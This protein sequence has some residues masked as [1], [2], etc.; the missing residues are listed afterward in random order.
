MRCRPALAALATAVLA[1]ACGGGG[2][3]APPTTSA[4][5]FPLGDL[6]VQRGGATVLSL[7]VEVADNQA[8]WEK[9]LMGV[10]ALGEEQ[11]MAFIF[12]E[13]QGAQ[14][15]MKDTLIPLDIAFWD[16][17]GRVV[18]VETMT[19]CSADPCHVYSSP[20]PY[21]G[22]VEV[23]GGLLGKVGV[24]TGDVVHFT[25]RGHTAAASP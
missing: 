3:A 6:T 16:A 7:T 9:G 20:Q 5:G 23:R 4:R 21:L 19:P 24:R 8:A 13:V 25:R 18:G 14:F 1:T 10:T 12:P 15:W 17:A 11:G 22:A 2:A